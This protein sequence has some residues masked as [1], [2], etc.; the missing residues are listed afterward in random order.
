M[1]QALSNPRIGELGVVSTMG[2][3]IL[4]LRRQ[5]GVEEAISEAVDVLDRGGLVVFPTET[6][7]GL[8]ARADRP[9]GVRRLCRV[10]ARPK[11]KPFTVHIGKRSGV[12]RYLNS[13]SPMARRFI[14]K[15]W[16]GPLT[17]LLKADPGEAA[18]SRELNESAVELLYHQRVI[19]IRCPDH[20]IAKELLDRICGP[21]VAASANLAGHHPPTTAEAA[22]DD[23]GGKAD[24]VLDAGATQY[25]KPSTIVR[26]DGDQY[27]L[28]REG[29]FDKRMIERMS[30]LNILF[31]C[32]GN[33]CRSP[34][35]SGI[36]ELLIAEK[37]GCE[38][39]ELG[40]RRVRV[41]SA[42]VSAYSGAPAAAHAV[43]V[44]AERGIDISGH[45]AER[46]TIELINAADYI[47]T[48]TASHGTSV[49][50]MVPSA[51]ERTLPLSADRDISDPIG[52][53]HQL[54]SE[55]ANT[56]EQT[57]EARIREIEL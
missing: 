20:A 17:L 22:I 42:G 28:V 50:S 24:L 43:E 46:L 34:M 49:V 48:M 47:F 16:P 38:V 55:T 51:A 40:S 6:V 29:V 57:I 13:P 2:V 41:T 53:D 30:V 45:S 14:K 18:V 5:E 7:Y 1:T 35:A 21:V 32:T 44:L 9:D 36:A 31:V 25:S 56:I 8:A 4:H 52:G 10:K 23:L 26:I 27:E 33:T 12:L 3:K 54:Y 19:G 37:L 39:N 15:G 11:D